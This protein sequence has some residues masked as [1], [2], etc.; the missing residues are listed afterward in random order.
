MLYFAYGSNLNISQMRVRCP[1]A[2]KVGPLILP[3]SQL[4]FRGVADVEYQPGA[5][6]HGGVWN[7]TPQCLRALDLYEGVRGDAEGMY[8]RDYFKVRY[9]GSIEDVLVYRMTRGGYYPPG[10]DYYQSILQGY[11]DFNLDPTHLQQ[12]ARRSANRETA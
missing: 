8:Y 12:A 9:H 10:R 11:K 7:I 2:K 4:V 5:V 3:G 6:V 1:Q